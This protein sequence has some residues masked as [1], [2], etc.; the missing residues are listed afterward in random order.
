MRLIVGTLVALAMFAA[1]PAVAQAPAGITI[2]MKVTDANGAAV[3]TVVGIKD[4]NLLVRTDKHDALLPSSSFTPN[5]GKLMFGMTQA[6][7]DAQI[8]QSLAAASSAI[9][10]GATVKGVAGTAVGTIES[11]AGGNVTIALQDGKKIA[12]PQAGLR[13]NADGSVTIGYSAAQ[14]EALV[15]GGGASSDA[16]AADKPAE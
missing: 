8:E 12:V 3:G 6:Q 15:Q 13:G 11:V 1:A 2:G 10:A 16:P 7:L 14:L 9:A 5:A 4:S